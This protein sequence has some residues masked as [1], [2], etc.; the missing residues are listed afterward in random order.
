MESVSRIFLIVLLSV[1]AASAVQ[2]SVQKSC[3]RLKALAGR[4]EG[5]METMERAAR[6]GEQAIARLGSRLDSRQDSRLGAQPATH[7]GTHPGT[8]LGAHLG[9]AG[10]ELDRVA[11]RM[12]L[13]GDRGAIAETMEDLWK[14]YGH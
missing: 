10:R 2:F 9:Q 1:S 13:Q 3:E 4:Y 5:T 12:R 14:A 11:G 6:C 8:R 7:P